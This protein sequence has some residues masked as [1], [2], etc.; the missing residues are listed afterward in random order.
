LFAIFIQM[1][2]HKQIK[3]FSKKNNSQWILC[4]SQTILKVFVKSQSKI[5]KWMEVTFSESK[6]R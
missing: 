1:L 5:H 3:K 6:S 2:I 4:Y